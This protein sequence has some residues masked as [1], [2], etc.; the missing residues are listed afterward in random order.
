MRSIKHFVEQSWLLV[1]ASFFFG[2]LIAVTNAALSTRIE[3]N[4]TLK[5]NTLARGLLPQAMQFVPLKEDIEVQALGGKPSRLQISKA[6]TD[7]RVVGWVF[8]IVGSG[9]GGGIELLVAV[10]AGFE[11][12]A[13]FDVLTSSETPGVGDKIMGDWFRKQFEGV[14]AK[15]LTLVKTGNPQEIDVQIVAISGATVSST[16][17]VTAINH[18]LPQVK[19]QLQQRG[20]IGNGN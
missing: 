18:Y 19:T 11:T 2:L 4:K 14:P 15:P 17:V 10:D 9:F 5:F 16:A 13:G 7:G 12:M 1:V 20:L 3:Q 8:K 6:L